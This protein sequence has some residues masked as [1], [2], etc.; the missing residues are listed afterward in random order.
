[1][2]KLDSVINVLNNVSQRMTNLEDIRTTYGN[3]D[4]PI[5]IDD[6]EDIQDDDDIFA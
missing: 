1:M 5:Q 6:E 2:N 3:D 4:A